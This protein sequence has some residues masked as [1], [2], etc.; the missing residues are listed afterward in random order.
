MRNSPDAI[1]LCGGV[2]VRLKSITGDS[3]KVMAP[4]LERPF[5]E[6]LLKQLRRN[7]FERA[8]LAVGYQKEAIR[9]HFCNRAFGM[10]LVYSEEPVALGTGGALQYAAHL[11]QSDVALIMNGDSYTNADLSEL[12]REHQTATADVTLVVVDM[13]NRN[14]AGA[15]IV[16]ESSRVITFAEK[17]YS[18]KPAYINAGIYMLSR[19]L[20]AKIPAGVQISLERELFPKWLIEGLVVRAV[21][22]AAQCVD[23]GTPER[24]K[25]AQLALCSVEQQAAS[26]R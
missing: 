9:D 6:L 24:Y 25:D 10:D 4:I 19:N 1:I 17:E 22:C 18:G 13:K 3:P 26:A 5:L 8:I 11:V 23:I 21:K 2:G 20:L 12:E 7:Q 16:D 14:D 15:V